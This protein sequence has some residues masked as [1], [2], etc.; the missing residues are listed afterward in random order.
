MQCGEQLHH[1]V[2]EEDSGG[3]SGLSPSFT[4]PSKQIFLRPISK[5]KDTEVAKSTA[6]CGRRLVVCLRNNTMGSVAGNSKPSRVLITST[7]SV[8]SNKCVKELELT[9][10]GCM[11]TWRHHVVDD[12]YIWLFLVPQLPSQ[13]RNSWEKFSWSWIVRGFQIPFLSLI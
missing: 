8:G 2:K 7:W 3:T 13:G 12:Y 6:Q 10:P 4:H 5:D 11:H 1:S 9:I